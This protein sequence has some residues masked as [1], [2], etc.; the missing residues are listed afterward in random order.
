VKGASTLF[1]LAWCAGC[2]STQGDSPA[3]TSGLTPTPTPWVQPGFLWQEGDELPPEAPP[4]T[5][6]YDND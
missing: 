4:N 2:A 6:R 5:L 3:P 1:L